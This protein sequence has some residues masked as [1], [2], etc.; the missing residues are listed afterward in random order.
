MHKHLLLTA[1]IMTG[2]TWLTVSTAGSLSAQEEFPSSPP[3]ESK[4]DSALPPESSTP[5]PAEQMGEEP[6]L[7]VPNS[8]AEQ[9][10][11]LSSSALI[12]MAVKNTQGEELG[13]IRELM[14]DP[15][16]GS[17]VYAMV[18]DAGILGTE[19]KSFAIPWDSLKVG[20][21]QTEVV[22]ELRDGTLPPAA[23]VTMDQH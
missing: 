3:V 22:V 1:L 10:T 17:I 23:Q 8:A 7:A 13:T 15:Q 19:T 18:A 16:H 6:P 5:L 14:V 11:L 9:P 20:L 4:A 21:N 2:S 12:G